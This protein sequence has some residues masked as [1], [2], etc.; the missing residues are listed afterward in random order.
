MTDNT[1]IQTPVSSGATDNPDAPQVSG[2]LQDIRQNA[3]GQ[4]IGYDPVQNSWVDTT[5]RKPYAEPTQQTQQTQPTQATQSTTTLPRQTVG[6]QDMVKNPQTGQTLVYDQSQNA[7]VDMLTRKPYVSTNAPQ[8]GAGGSWVED[9]IAQQDNPAAKHGLLRRVWDYANTPIADFVLPQGVKTAD[10]IKATAFE[11]LYGEA[12]IPG[13]N[14]FD[15]KSA[16][17]F[18]DGKK[19]K[20]DSP[21]K[22]YVKTFLNGVAK[23][24][25]STAA[26]FTSPL[27]LATIGAGEAAQTPGAVGK[28]AKAVG[29]LAGT[30]FAGQG[31]NEVYTGEKD[32]AQ[33]GL[34]SENASQIAG[35]LGETALG[36]AGISHVSHVFSPEAGRV[37]PVEAAENAPGL[38]SK[39]IAKAVQKSGLPNGERGINT[40]GESLSKD[41]GISLKTPLE[42]RPEAAIRGGMANTF[43]SAASDSQTEL[44]EGVASRDVASDLADK[45]KARSSAGYK[46]LDDASGGRWQ[47]F[48]K[49]ID[50]LRNKADEL[51]GIDDDKADA[52]SKQAS[53]IE[54]TRDALVKQLVADGKIDKNTA[55]QAIKDWAQQSSLTRVD[56]VI[57]ANIRPESA[58]RPEVVTNPTA[59]EKGLQRLY[60]DPRQHL[61]RAM[62]S[63]DA[64]DKLL[65]GVRMGNDTLKAMEDFKAIPPKQGRALGDIVKP[66]VSTKSIDW[67][68]VQRDFENLNAGQRDA[69]FGE[70]TPKVRKFINDRV[71]RQALW[72]TAKKVVPLG[73]G[74]VIGGEFLYHWL[75][76][77]HDQ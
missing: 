9:K 38:V 36:V 57:K 46:A 43:D 6:A 12:Y 30:A 8:S 69:M 49:S 29:P 61:Q 28:I 10:L 33:H 42:I 72:S 22:T 21:T 71:T 15:T 74:S 16:I 65:N 20:G 45:L 68:G 48:D 63:Q 58:S 31:A 70:A 60:D 5:T 14:D 76:G 11:H 40:L 55:D 35:G 64:A 53:D 19:D 7:W 27:S 34:T 47:R 3:A 32:V 54:D 4:K 41:L 51:A 25:S 50:N 75:F 73:T 37:V 62:G 59:L 26:S 77:N 56:K 1:T 39:Q 66:H 24:A 44:S 17:H 13:I 52:Y 67:S 2:D 23:D 18:G